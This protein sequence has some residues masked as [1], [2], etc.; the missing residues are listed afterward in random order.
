MIRAPW[1]SFRDFVVMREKGEDDATVRG[2]NLLYYGLT[3][4]AIS[5]ALIALGVN[6]RIPG[7]SMSEV[8]QRLHNELDTVLD[9]AQVVTY[10]VQWWHWY[11]INNGY[12]RSWPT[13]DK[14]KKEAP[15]IE[16]GA[17]G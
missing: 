1:S 16:A 8:Q 14:A 6:S 11:R 4:S 5:S 3:P 10:L 2:Y 12:I 9:R 13:R 17:S 7:A 15:A